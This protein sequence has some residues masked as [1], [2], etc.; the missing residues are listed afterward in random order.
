MEV[1]GVRGAEAGDLAAG[2]RPG[3]GVARMRVHH[4]ADLREGA[5]ERHVRGEIGRR[6]QRAFHDVAVEVGDHHV[7][8][9]HLVV[10]HAARLDDA[11]AVLARHA[12]GVAE[13]V[14]HQSA[15]DQF[16]IGF[17]N[18]SS[19]RFQHFVLLVRC[20]AMRRSSGSIVADLHGRP[21]AAVRIAK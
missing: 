11:Q 6:P 18:F 8:G 5:V 19:Q 15:A 3:G 7:G 2:L 13:R 17:Q 9:R 14:D 20:A 16:E 12:A 4:A 10:G 21:T 1:V